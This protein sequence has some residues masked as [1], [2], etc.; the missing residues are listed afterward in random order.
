MWCRCCKKKSTDDDDKLIR[1]SPLICDDLEKP[2]EVF[3]PQT[4][5]MS[6]PRAI[7][8]TKNEA[9]VELSPQIKKRASIS[10]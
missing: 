3:K 8:H 1:Q 7:K 4:E 6:H 10:E 5:A 2:D 9:K